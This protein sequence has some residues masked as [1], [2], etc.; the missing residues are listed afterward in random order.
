MILLN[1][2]VTQRHSSEIALDDRFG[3][4]LADAIDIF[5]VHLVVF[6]T[7]ELER[8]DIFL[9]A[10]LLERLEDSVEVDA[11]IARPDAVLIEQ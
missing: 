6:R 2:S 4:L 5:R 3:L 8:D 7:E 10:D 11:A 1:D 9:P